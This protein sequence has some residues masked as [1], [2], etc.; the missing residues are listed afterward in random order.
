M[1]DKYLKDFEKLNTYQKEA[2]TLM[3]KHVVLNAVV[4]VEKPQY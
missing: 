1:L 2:V 4:E 3:E